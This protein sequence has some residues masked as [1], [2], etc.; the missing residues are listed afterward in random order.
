MPFENFPD[1]MTVRQVQEALRIGRNTAYN[2]VNNGD[3]HSFRIGKN[4][5][6][7]KKCLIDYI[8]KYS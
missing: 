6:V 8:L 1:V 4:I 5:K 7:P 3:I 2:L